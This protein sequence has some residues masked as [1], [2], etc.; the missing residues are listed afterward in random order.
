MHLVRALLSLIVLI[1]RCSAALLRTRGE[2]AIVELALRQQL[3][4]Y[5]YHGRR[6]RLGPLDRT[7]WVAL[8]VLWPRWKNA[9]VVVRPGTVVRWHREGFR[10]H[11]TSISKPG[12][13]RP[14]ISKEVQQLIPCSLAISCTESPSSY[15]RRAIFQF[16][17]ALRFLR[18][19]TRPPRKTPPDPT[20]DRDRV[21]TP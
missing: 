16:G 7:F 12:P 21:P 8:S 6:P 19:V 4:T 9:L 11:W 17:L 15:W 3:A 5:T 10:R 13:G 1:V 18:F 14:P 20:G 2:Q